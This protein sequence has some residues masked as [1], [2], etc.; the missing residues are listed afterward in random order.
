VHVEET[1]AELLVAAVMKPARPLATVMPEAPRALSEVVDRALALAI[2]DRW[3]DARAMQCALRCAYHMI[4]GRPM[5]PPPRATT[6][7]TSRTRM[8]LA[9]RGETQAT[10]RSAKG[11]RA[12]RK[13]MLWGG[14]VLA[15]GAVLSI[16]AAVA[17]TRA[18]RATNEGTPQG[19]EPARDEDAIALNPIE[20]APPRELAPPSF[21]RLRRHPPPRA[22]SAPPAL[23]PRIPLRTQPR[24]I[25][26]RRY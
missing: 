9:Q 11:L 15:I 10:T 25:Y 3:G 17:A 22:T 12:W 26:D 23:P 6:A 18:K 2:E 14:S 24:D 1:V 4:V 21:R 13:L 7:D 20:S 5:P 8:A 16:P 19:E